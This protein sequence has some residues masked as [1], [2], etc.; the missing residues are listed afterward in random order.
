MAAD[1]KYKLT[2]KNDGWRECDYFSR[3]IYDS[4]FQDLWDLLRDKQLADKTIDELQNTEIFK[5]SPYKNLN[6]DQKVALEKILAAISEAQK[7]NAVRSAPIVVDGKPGTGKTILA[8]FL[9]KMLK[10]KAADKKDP[11][12]GKKIFLIEPISSIRKSIRNAVKVV[13]GIRAKDIIGP[14]DLVKPEYGLRAD[15][16]PGIDICLVDEAH[17]LKQFKNLGQQTKH[18][19]DKCALLGREAANT[20]QLD[21]IYA[22]CSQSV[23]FYDSR[24]SVL[25]AD[26]DPLTFKDQLGSSFTSP[27]SLDKQMRVKG[28]GEYLDYIEAILKDRK[29]SKCTFPAY[30]L[31]LHKT[32]TSFNRSFVS[33]LEIAELT[34]MVAGFGWK[35]VSHNDK[36]RTQTDIHIEGIDKRW[37]TEPEDWVGKGL[38]DQFYANEVG[39]IHSVQGH[40]LSYAYVILGPEIIYNR[41]IKRIEIDLKN[42]FDINGKRS[43]SEQR[44][45]ST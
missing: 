2:N 35:W 37:N 1:G 38:A 34:R 41:E 44:S 45:M 43:A 28:G 26:I 23:F 10:D 22:T 20:N 13:P 33:H 18:Y 4:M 5:F 6:L 15:G 36:T 31:C 42:Y 17:R 16:Q 8:I 14:Y 27:I 12:Y 7:T 39:C 11:L 19:M 21:W 3:S 24:Q 32:F 25:P 9:L 30:E 40:D 29:P